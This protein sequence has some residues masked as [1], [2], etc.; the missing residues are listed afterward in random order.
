[1]TDDEYKKLWDAIDDCKLVPETDRI[2]IKDFW[3]HI[4]RHYPYVAPPDRVLMI[5]RRDSVKPNIIEFLWKAGTLDIVGGPRILICVYLDDEDECRDDGGWVVEYEIDSIEGVTVRGD[6][7]VDSWPVQLLLGIHHSQAGDPSCDDDELKRL[8]T[9][10]S[11]KWKEDAW[12]H[13]FPHTILRG[14]AYEDL[15]LLDWPI[16]PFIIEVMK[17]DNWIG[18]SWLLEKITGIRPY[19]KQAVTYANN[20]AKGNVELMAECW[21][22]W[23]RER[24]K[25]D[26]S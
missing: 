25:S 14:E 20:I 13:S 16:V 23:Y 10:T 4:Y 5:E 11:N 26:G 6:D 7:A 15:L 1:M 8:F 17:T 22:S 21:I 9:I 24:E 3:S 2:Y 19:N 12:V 18:W